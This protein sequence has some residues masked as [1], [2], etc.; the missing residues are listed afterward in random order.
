MGEIKAARP[1]LA[2]DS[3]ARQ[4][5]L[6]LKGTPARFAYRSALFNTSNKPLGAIKQRSRRALRGQA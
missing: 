4:A 3:P 1:A 6:D 5:P 2:K